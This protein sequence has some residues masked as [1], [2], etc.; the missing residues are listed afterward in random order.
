MF[1]F[2]CHAIIGCRGTGLRGSISL[3]SAMAWQLTFCAG[4][5][6]GGG[7]WVTGASSACSASAVAV[8]EVQGGDGLGHRDRQLDGFIRAQCA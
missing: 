3:S 8:V 2:W 5:D 4:L 1:C 6:A 7:V